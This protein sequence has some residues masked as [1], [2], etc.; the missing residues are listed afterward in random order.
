MTARFSAALSALSLA[1]GLVASP[2]QAEDGAALYAAQCAKCH[3]ADGRADTPVGKAT[4]AVSLLDPKYASDAELGKRIRE[5]PKHAAFVSRLKP[6]EIEAVA[7]TVQE[8]ARAA[9][10]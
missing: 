2:V 3:G 8:M 4:K 7:R 5:N 10:P 6:E 9:K 1:F